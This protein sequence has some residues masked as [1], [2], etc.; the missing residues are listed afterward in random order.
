MVIQLYEKWWAVPT[1][2]EFERLIEEFA[3][4]PP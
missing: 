2:R 3:L 4:L 1:L